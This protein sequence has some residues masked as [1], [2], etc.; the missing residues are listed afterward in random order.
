LSRWLLGNAGIA[1]KI[2][3][4][5]VV[6]LDTKWADFKSVVA[7]EEASVWSNDGK[8]SSITNFCPEVAFDVFGTFASSLAKY[9]KEE[10]SESAHERLGREDADSDDPRWRWSSFTG[11]HFSECREY[12][13]F[14]DKKPHTTM[15]TTDQNLALL[16]VKEQIIAKFDKGHWQDI[17]LL[18]DSLDL[19][20]GHPRLLLGLNFGDDDYDGNVAEVLLEMVRKDPK[21]LQVIVDYVDGKFR[22]GP[23]SPS[24]L[25]DRLAR[26]K[27]DV[28]ISYSH[29]NSK[30]ASQIKKA[31]EDAKITCFMSEKDL[32][33]GDEFSSRI[34]DALVHS[35]EMCVLCSPDSLT[36]EWVLT[37]WG[38]AWAMEMTLVPILHQVGFDKLPKRLQGVQGTD[39][40]DL[41][42]YV[43]EVAA[44]L[45]S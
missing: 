24:K 38:A 29:A 25:V 3:K 18:T 37:E 33:T 7:E 9:A 2:D 17:A 28:F 23:V 14:G 12:S 4:E 15:S 19:V 22:A 10:D 34:R 35:R 44:R 32:R 20:N 16:K 6:R 27:F 30:Q 1:T 13:L 39:L 43:S 26:S 11:Q 31:L 5:D 40:S 8:F 21:N 41:E 42:R 45:G 36:S